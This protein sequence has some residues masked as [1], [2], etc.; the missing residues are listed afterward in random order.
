MERRSSRET[1]WFSASQEI[2]NILWSRR[3]HCRNFHVRTVQ[4]DIIKVLFIHQLMH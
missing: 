1:N 4:L 2:P 3:V